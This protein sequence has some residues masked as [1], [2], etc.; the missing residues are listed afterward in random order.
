MPRWSLA[1]AAAMLCG[2]LSTSAHAWQWM[3]EDV[4]TSFALGAAVALEDPAA[5]NLRMIF[6]CERADNP[7]RYYLLEIRGRTV[8][9]ALVEGAKSTA[10]GVPGVLPELNKDQKVEFSLQR[11]A[12]RVGVICNRKVVFRAYDATL[13][14]P[15]VGYELAAGGK[16]DDIWLQPYQEIDAADTFEREEGAKDE[17]EALTGSWQLISLREDRQAGQMKAELSANAF[18]YFGK[19]DTSGLAATGQWWWRNAEYSVSVRA[20]DDAPALGLAFYVQDKD[21]YLLLRWESR[22][23]Q[24]PAPPSLQLIAV[25]DGKQTVLAQRAGGFL[26]YQWFRLQARTCDD[27]ITCLVDGERILTVATDLIGQGRIGMYV[28]G[29]SGAWFDDMQVRSYE[30]MREPF[31]REVPG[32]WKPA[33]G[34]WQIADGVA[35]ARTA[36]RSLLTVGP[37]DWQSYAFSAQVSD[38]TGGRGLL[39]GIGPD[40]SGYL[41]RWAPTGAK[42]PYAGKA[43][44]VKLGNPEQIIAQKPLPGDVPARVLATVVLEPD[45]LA[46][47]LGNTRVV[48]AVLQGPLRGGAGLYAEGAAGA[49]FRMARMEHLPVRTMARVTKEYTDSEEHFEMVEWATTRNPW[50]KPPDDANPKVWWT[51]GDYY[52]PLQVKFEL[53]QLGQIEGAMKV[54]IEGDRNDPTAGALL[55]ITATRGTRK[56]AF[57][58]E[59]GGKELG[60]AE[61][62]PASDHCP[63]SIERRGDYVVVTADGKIL[64]SVAWQPAA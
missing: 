51:K 25:V 56:L 47:V 29:K 8:S 43:Q 37:A 9:L 11:D 46:G 15:A 55:T 53:K 41:F 63:I 50:I 22:D 19:S 64:I 32:K 44:I 18:S 49:S 57:K 17:W 27:E 16:V 14:G 7:A 26:P 20:R 60:T 24:L 13:H 58:L 21:N 1:V 31:D 45:Y 23:A 36:N 3:D 61:A 42:V 38:S 54:T 33:G 52:G 6:G 28:E 48:D 12:W 34:A 4:E 40:G 2:L 39:A 10:L 30:D 5:L 62:E 59:A 35:R